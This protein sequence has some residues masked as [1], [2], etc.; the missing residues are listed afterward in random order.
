MTIERTRRA[1]FGRSAAVLGGAGFFSL[2]STSARGQSPDNTPPDV[3]R[4]F[5]RDGRVKEFK[6]NTII[7]HLPQQDAGYRTF[8]ALLGIYRD[9]PSYAFAR[10]LAILPPSS[11]HMTIF[12]GANDLGRK[13]GLWPD[14]IALDTPITLCNALLA[15]RLFSFP[16]DC[17]L[18]IRMRVDLAPIVRSSPITVDLKPS[19]DQELQKLRRLRDRLSDLLRIRA[20]DHDR[21][22]FH[23]TIAYQIAWF[24]EAEE[25]AYAIPRRRWLV[26]LQQEAPVISFGAPEYCTFNDMF[27]FRR[28]LFIT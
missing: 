7:C 25:D 11:Y 15:E 23:I 5:F 1:L 10:K 20:P 24:D 2:A 6:G 19:D 17:E 26:R 13:P 4:K 18:P 14:D 12:G 8:D 21:Y 9:V 16:L 3:G 28:Q 22:G 27:S